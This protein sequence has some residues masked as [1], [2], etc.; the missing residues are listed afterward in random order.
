MLR[1]TSIKNASLA[2]SVPVAGLASM[3]SAS[4]RPGEEAERVV[5]A[6]LLVLGLLAMVQVAEVV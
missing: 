6:A 1:R 4:I 2:R 5:M 3:A